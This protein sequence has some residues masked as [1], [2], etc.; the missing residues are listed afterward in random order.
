MD[1]ANTMRGRLMLACLVCSAFGASVT[2]F[3]QRRD[4]ADV[5]DGP[6]QPQMKS[7]ILAPSIVEADKAMHWSLHE[8][9][10]D[11]LFFRVARACPMANSMIP[12]ALTA[13][14][15]CGV[16]LWLRAQVKSCELVEG[17]RLLI[18]LPHF[19]CLVGSTIIVLDSYDV[20]QQAGMVTGDSGQLV[21]LNWAGAA[22]GFFTMWLALRYNSRIW[23]ECPRALVMIGLAIN[24]CGCVLYSGGL[25]SL[26]AKA[27]D[28]TSILLLKA[29]RALGGFGQGFVAQFMVVTI[30]SIT[31]KADMGNQMTRIFLVNAVGVGAGPILASAGHMMALC[32]S[33]QFNL[34]VAP[35]MHIILVVFGLLGTAILFPDM[36]QLTLPDQCTP[37]LA[38]DDDAGPGGDA[39]FTSRHLLIMGC[40]LL[41]VLRSFVVSGVEVGTALLLEQGYGMDR[42]LVGLTV[43]CTFMVAIPVR[44]VHQMLKDHLTTVGWFRV[45]ASLAVLGTC[46]LFRAVSTVLPHGLM[47]LL[48]DSV[49]FPSAFL[50]DG[51]SYGILMVN[52]FPDGSLLDK[53]TCAL[54]CNV[55]GMSLG[56]LTGPW[57]TRY[58]LE[59]SAGSQDT[60]AMMQLIACCLTFGLFE[61]TIRPGVK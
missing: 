35:L 51:I 37:Q 47:I 7:S 40:T 49:I 14:V 58:Q 13:C 46:L 17:V 52:V 5:S 30:Q 29:A 16:L 59:S 11:T 48:A 31:S 2:N 61:A 50:A 44:G 6:D 38:V 26:E 39:Y 42:K 25:Y 22:C 57:M 24:M 18:L 33:S 28:R 56:R 20:A 32:P 54:F 36:T 9:F 4:M 43:G 19:I 34:L 10:A 23:L 55:L 41:F 21:G 15:M 12:A 1:G 3:R 27:S 60:Y 45:F 8:H 53:N